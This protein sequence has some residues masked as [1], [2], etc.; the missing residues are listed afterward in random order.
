[1]NRLDPIGF[2][3]LK[4]SSKKFH[5]KTTIPPYL[6]IENGF[7]K[8]E[9]GYYVSH[10][11][12]ASLIELLAEQNC[13]KTLT[14]CE[15]LGHQRWSGKTLGKEFLAFALYLNLCKLFNLQHQC[16]LGLYFKILIKVQRRY[17]TSSFWE[18]WAIYCTKIILK[19]HEES[20]TLL[21]L[22]KQNLG[23]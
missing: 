16:L 19:C 15:H 11:L 12:L 7:K 5:L 1:M 2:F 18:M 3:Q 17:F 4:D 23:T 20:P 22:E 14:K 13:R 9:V 8:L 21:A 10:I 6:V